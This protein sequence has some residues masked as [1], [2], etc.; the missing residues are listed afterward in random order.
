MP[1]GVE[2]TESWELLY[3]LA[4]IQ[5][6][7]GDKEAPDVLEDLNSAFADSSSQQG[8]KF[9]T[10]KGHEALVETIL[11]FASKSSKALHSICLKAFRASARQLSRGGVQ[12]MV[13]VSTSTV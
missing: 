2:S 1:S 9:L 8:S 4:V 3:G 6:F 12:S 13:R 7:D 5:L 10:E 11:G